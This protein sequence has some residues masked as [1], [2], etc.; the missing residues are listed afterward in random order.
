MMKMLDKAIRMVAS[1]DEP[2]NYVYDNT[3]RTLKGLQA[4]GVSSDEARIFSQARMYG[5]KPEEERRRPQLVFLFD[6][7]LGRMGDAWK[8]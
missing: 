1:L 5:P 4:K 3:L 7:T 8:N 2:D 6:G